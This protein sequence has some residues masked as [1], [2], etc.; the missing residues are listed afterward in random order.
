M[1][2]PTANDLG[3]V[4]GTPPVVKTATAIA[5]ANTVTVVAA[6]TTARITVVAIAASAA[7]AVTLI[8]LKDGSTLKW[9]ACT[10]TGPACI[11]AATGGML[12]TGTVNTA[13]NM[14]ATT[15]GLAYVSVSYVEEVP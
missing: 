12:F 6:N 10:V 15:A 1:A 11:T 7:A 8:E 13:L 2:Y 3:T 9:Q 14:T 4:R 5:N